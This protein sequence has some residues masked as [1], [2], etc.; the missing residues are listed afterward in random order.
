MIW[1][2]GIEN[3]THSRRQKEHHVFFLCEPKEF[4]KE[5][6]S[7][8]KKFAILTLVCTF[9]ASSI[10]FSQDF[11]P[12][13]FDPTAEG[14]WSDVQRTTLNVPKVAD[15]SVTLDAN[16]SSAEYGGFQAVNV[17][18]GVNAWILD[19][20]P[21]REFDG[22]DDTSFDFYLAHDNDYLYVGV[23]VKD[24]VVISDNPNAAFW[25][26][27]AIELVFDAENWKFDTNM[28]S[29]ASTAGGH[30]YVNYEG[31]FSEWDE[32][33]NAKRRDHFSQGTDWSYGPE[34]DIFGFGQAVNGGW[35][36]EVRFSKSVLAGDTG[37]DLDNGHVMGFNIGLDDDDGHYDSGD[38]TTTME[39]QYFWANRLRAIGWNRTELETEYFNEEELARRAWLDPSITLFDL[40]INSNGR[41][42]GGGTGDIVF[43]AGT[44]VKHWSVF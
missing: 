18:P 2:G 33:A 15:G 4:G 21:E 37:L 6:V 36:M 32:A 17:T 39:L 10:T 43:Q 28:D 5:C 12:L 42:T 34:G 25:R 30:I 26:D 29:T 41:L 23:M 31:R 3:S 38:G 40:A 20:P 19:Y 35:N 7:H 16:I 24:D 1:K 14:P 27:D 44:S 13:T 8:M 11:D 22:P 9:A